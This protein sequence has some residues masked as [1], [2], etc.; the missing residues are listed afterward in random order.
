MV[1]MAEAFL[2]VLEAKAINDALHIQ[3]PPNPLSFCRYVDDSHSRFEKEEYADKFLDVLNKQ[4]PKIQYTIEKESTEKKLQFL[5]LN[6]INNGKGKYEFSIHRKNA[7]TNVQIKP[8]SSHDPKILEGVFKGFVNRA[9]SLCN[10]KY[11]EEEIEFLKNVF[12]KNG[13]DRQS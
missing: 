5:D 4:H 11:Q 9:I 10:G 6:V 7:I 3:P 8:E 2:Q 13:Y 1:V 12:H